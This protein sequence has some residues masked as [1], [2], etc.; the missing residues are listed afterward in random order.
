MA[1]GGAPLWLGQKDR[2]TANDRLEHPHIDDNA[3]GQ[4]HKGRIVLIQED[5]LAVQID[6]S[7]DAGLHLDPALARQG[8]PQ[9]A[10]VDANRIGRGQQMPDP[11]GKTAA[12]RRRVFPKQFGRINTGQLLAKHMQHL[13][14][15]A[16]PLPLT[17]VPS[18]RPATGSNLLHLAPLI[19]FSCS[20]LVEEGSP[21]D[22]AKA[23]QR[24]GRSLM[25]YRRNDGRFR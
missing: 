18:E 21:C 19:A 20:P 14:A 25:I 16:K 12:H 15:A 6:P 24:L 11:R 10:P 9:L 8:A 22:M 3:A 1:A 17:I 7:R 4:H 2:A 13:C 23:R 5:R